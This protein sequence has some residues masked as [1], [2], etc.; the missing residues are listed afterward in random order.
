VLSS[1]VL[2]RSLLAPS[3]IPSLDFLLGL[4]SPMGLAAE[5]P[6]NAP[7]P[8]ACQI[9]Y[10][11][12]EHFRNAKPGEKSVAAPAFERERLP[13]SRVEISNDAAARVVE[14]RGAHLP[15]Q[16]FVKIGQR[17]GGNEGGTLE[18]TVLDSSGKRLT[19]FPQIMRNPLTRSG[20]TQSKGI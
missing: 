3:I 19:G 8:F 12:P 5:E 7:T 14:G 1:N 18:V 16:F 13:T 10:H 15:Y 20:D 17:G 4:W 6:S 2:R 11:F 9:W